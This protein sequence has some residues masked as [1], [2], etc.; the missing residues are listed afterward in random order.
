MYESVYVYVCVYE[1]PAQGNRDYIR[2]L[3]YILF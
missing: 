3:Y 1:W 2:N